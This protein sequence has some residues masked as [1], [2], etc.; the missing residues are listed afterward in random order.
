MINR[1]VMLSG[2][3]CAGAMACPAIGWEASKERQVMAMR[4]LDP[5]FV[6]MTF[7]RMDDI[8]VGVTLR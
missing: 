8:Q 1:I 6:R 3:D 7:S 2:R 4:V 5:S